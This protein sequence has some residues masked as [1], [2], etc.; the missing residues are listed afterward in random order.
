MT[1]DY[2]NPPK[3]F[4]YLGEWCKAW[5]NPETGD[6]T[7]AELCDGLESNQVTIYSDEVERL[8][9]FIKTA[10]P[11][12]REQSQRNQVAL[13]AEAGTIAEQ[14]RIANAEALHRAGRI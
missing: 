1:Y 5:K 14:Q 13:A 3:D 4:V 6:I 2:M 10:D 9:E 12:T 8:I 7:I 11:S